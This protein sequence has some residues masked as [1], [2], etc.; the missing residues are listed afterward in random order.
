MISFRKFLPLFAL[1]W[2]SVSVLATACAPNG[3]SA[4]TAT[5]VVMRLARSYE[6][7][8]FA[9]V[10]PTDTPTMTPTALPTLTPTATATST[11]SPTR[12][13]TRRP[14]WTPTIV[15]APAM[16]SQVVPTLFPTQS[17]TPAIACA[18]LPN[19]DYTPFTLNSPP[20]DRPAALHPDLNL[21]LRGYTPTIGLA[22][23]IDYGGPTASQS[24]QLDGLF[25]DRRGPVLRA[26][27]KVYDWNW[28]T[29][30]RGDPIAD[31]AVTMIG[32]AV[33]PGESIHVPDA[34]TN[35][36]LGF[37]A[38]VLYAAP[39]RITIKYTGEDNAIHGYTLQLENICVEPRLLALY[40]QLN[41]EGRSQLPALHSGQ[42]IG[43]AIGD[44]IDIAVRD[45]GAYLDPR[46]RKDFWRGH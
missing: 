14:T 23:P 7:T 22:G 46:S 36:G 17:P 37:D 3:R 43:R 9:R 6:P 35:I 19:E 32:A 20:T 29:D 40:Q 5:P 34:G 25:F 12:I 18:D 44:E 28:V 10:V 1:V 15:I 24:P 45:T 21:A 2:L 30:T 38:L 26:L 27:Y 31:P 16:G 4:A 11:Q 33:A 41:A 8:K 39:T 13:P 42:A